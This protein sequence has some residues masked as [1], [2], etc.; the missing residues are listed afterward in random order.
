VNKGKK[1][2]N[3]DEASLV[4]PDGGVAIDHNTQSR[5]SLAK[6]RCVRVY[7]ASEEYLGPNGHDLGTHWLPALHMIS[8]KAA[9]IAVSPIDGSC[10]DRRSPEA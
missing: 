3:G 2:R 8:S 10:N 6:P 7:E 1:K 5:E 4:I 9:F